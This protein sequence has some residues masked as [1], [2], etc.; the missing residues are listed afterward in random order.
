MA[1]MSREFI[2]ENSILGY[3]YNITNTF[4]VSRALI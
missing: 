1:T 4:T 3:Y 2:A